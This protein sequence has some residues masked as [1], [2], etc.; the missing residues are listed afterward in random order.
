M[1]WIDYVTC[2]RAAGLRIADIKAYVELFQ[3]G[4]ATLPARVRMLERHADVLRRRIT[5]LSRSLDDIERKLIRY[6]GGLRSNE[7]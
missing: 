7:R 2:L 6:R 5:E 4:E 3:Q 1:A